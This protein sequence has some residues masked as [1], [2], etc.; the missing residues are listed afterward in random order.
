MQRQG[1]PGMGRARCVQDA[2][3]WSAARDTRLADRL[4]CPRRQMRQRP[5]ADRLTPAPRK[6]VVDPLCLRWPG[7]ACHVGHFAPLGEVCPLRPSPPAIQF[8]S[9]YPP[10]LFAGLADRIHPIV[11]KHWEGG[12]KSL[13]RLGRVT[14]RGLTQ[15]FFLAPGGFELFSQNQ[16]SNGPSANRSQA[17]RAFSRRWTRRVW[18]LACQSATGRAFIFQARWGG[19]SKV[20]D[21]HVETARG[22]HADFRKI[23]KTFFPRRT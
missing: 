2:A 20:W 23:R 6:E 8:F 11:P 13:G 14:A 5:W 15:R 4:R 1:R 7:S 3:S 19:R 18:A 9:T 21:P 17:I 12:V 10:E 22:P 16:K